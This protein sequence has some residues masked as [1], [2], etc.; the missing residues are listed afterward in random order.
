M[1]SQTPTGWNQTWDKSQAL[2]QAAQTSIAA[3]SQTRLPVQRINILEASVLD[4]EIYNLL[5]MS[6]ATV[7][8]GAR[9]LEQSAGPTSTWRRFLGL[10]I[11][12]A[13]TGATILTN[14]STPGQVLQSVRY[15]NERMFQDA[16]TRGVLQLPNDGPTRLQRGF[17]M[18]LNVIMPYCWSSIRYRITLWLGTLIRNQRNQRNQR[19]QERIINEANATVPRVVESGVVEVLE[20]PEVVVGRWID[21]AE[22]TWGLASLINL[23]IFFKNGIYTSLEDRVLSMRQVPLRGGGSRMLNFDFQNRQLVFSELNDF[24]IYILPML[25]VYSTM[26]AS[27]RMGYRFTGRV[28]RL[29]RHI[30]LL[31]SK[32]KIQETVKNDRDDRDDRDDGVEEK[33]TVIEACSYC[34]QN[35]ATTPYITSCGCTM[36]YY[37]LRTNID[38]VVNDKGVVQGSCPSCGCI[39]TSS[40]RLN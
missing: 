17:W 10:G 39:M 21:I 14:S 11:R 3:H 2:I 38:P 37:C 16:R 19:E 4:N 7:L 40:R 25:R 33:K 35:P 34:E 36:C 8:G 22:G 9:A 12:L 23:T 28:K 20:P 27:K 18:L 1:T 24:A 15:R 30:G 31:S 5:E 29:G 32:N 26:R 6:F 13:V